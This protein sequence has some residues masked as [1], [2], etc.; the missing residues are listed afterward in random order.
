[1]YMTKNDTT[2]KIGQSTAT[3]VALSW[4]PETRQEIV[5]WELVY[6]RYIHCEL[7]THRAFSRNSA[8]SRA[9]PVA[10]MVKEVRENPCYFDEIRHNQ[11]GMT[12][13]DLVAQD[14]ADVFRGQWWALS[15]MAAR[16]AEDWGVKKGFAK[17]TVN[18]IL[19]PFSFIR[20]LVTATAVANFFKLREAEDAQPEMRNLAGAMRCAMEKAERRHLADGGTASL[21]HLPYGD[22][23]EETDVKARIIR[24]VAAC[25]RVSVMR[26]DGKKTTFEEDYEFV[27]RLYEN[28]H[29][30]P[31]EH[32]ARASRC[33]GRY[34][35]LRDWASLRYMLDMDCCFLFDE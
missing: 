23:I 33:E 7:L 25:A 12:G 11:K 31:F 20:T 35:N 18:R 6:P 26:G 13:G 10:T 8:S 15:N 28:R 17:Q 1:M 14:D 5:T 22:L 27:K 19:E 32:V 16:F 9:T 29:M 21:I 34:Y 30:S 2:V 3:V 24:S 4:S